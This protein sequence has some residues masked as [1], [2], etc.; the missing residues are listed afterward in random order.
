MLGNY[1]PNVGT[2]AIS[3][4]LTYISKYSNSN[5]PFIAFFSNSQINKYGDCG[6]TVAHQPVALRARVRLPPFA[7]L[8]SV[9]SLRVSRI[10]RDFGFLSTRDLCSTQILDVSRSIEQES[11][12]VKYSKIQNEI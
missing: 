7:L 8:N 2:Y 6:V 11:S 9:A 12:K 10:F 5:K 3:P 4:S 1:V